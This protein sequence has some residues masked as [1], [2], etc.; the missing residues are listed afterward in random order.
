MNSA[1]RNCFSLASDS[2]S[3]MSRIS[4][5]LFV[6]WRRSYAPKEE[7][8]PSKDA[9]RSEIHTNYFKELYKNEEYNSLIVCID[10]FLRENECKDDEDVIY[11]VE[12]DRANT[13]WNYAVDCANKIQDQVEAQRMSILDEPIPDINV[14]PISPTVGHKT[15]ARNPFFLVFVAHILLQWH[16]LPL[17]PHSKSS[18]CLEKSER[19]YA[20]LDKY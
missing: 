5:V 7:D 9:Y 20:L 18:T 1:A 6:T 4:D 17:F 11:L 15:A 10:D 8:F 16:K 13:R 14:V 12:G 3:D 19:V 2:S